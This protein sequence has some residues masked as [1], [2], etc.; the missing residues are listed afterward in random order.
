MS[1]NLSLNIDIYKSLYLIRRV[2]ERIRDLYFEDEM[3]TPMHMSM[4]GEA[5]AVGICQA[6]GSN[7]QMFGTYRS[8]ALYLTK[9]METDEFF[10]EM[11]GKATGVARGKAGSMH[12]ASPE[13]G[14]MVTSAVVGTTL[15]WAL[16][17]A[18]AAKYQNI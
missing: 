4:G 7:S 13:H 16:G 5:I 12:L 17:D 10:A 1:K 8:H 3:K 15:P 18:F 2:E 6:A 11:Y 14:L 9:T